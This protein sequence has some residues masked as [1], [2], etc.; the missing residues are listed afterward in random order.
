MTRFDAIGFGAL[1]VDRLFKV[2]KIA[3]AEEESFVTEYS[4]TCGGSAAN[5]IVSLS[6]LQCKTG[7]IGKIGSDR[8]GRILLADFHKEHVDT[9]GIIKGKQ[10]RSGTVMGFIDANGE[11]ALYVDPGINDEITWNEIN[12]EYASQAKFLHLTSF[13]GKK[14]FETQKKLLQI[15]PD[16]VK[17]SLDPGE[18]YARR[19]LNALRP[20]L[21]KAYVVMPN[22]PELALLF[23]NGDYKK[24]ASLLLR[25]GAKIVA[26]KQGREGCYVTDGK[27]NFRIK[28]LKVKVKDTTG[29]GD[30]FCAGFLYG[31]INGKGIQE[32]GKIGNLVA[33]KCVIKVGARYGLPK[34]SDLEN[35]ELL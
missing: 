31:L 24:N 27:E 22:A 14:S 21:E 4:E 26:V 10:E 34:L 2:N 5:T 32:C 6:R 16:N 8:E 20:F 30:S 11:R 29:A 1:N 17:I 23:G 12:V 19:G 33:S 25:A 3:S 9:K 7:F 15:L 13:V 28:A 18:I 35:A